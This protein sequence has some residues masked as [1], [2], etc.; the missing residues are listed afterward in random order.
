MSVQRR[1]VS[2]TKY[3]QM[4]VSRAQGVFRQQQ[5]VKRQRLVALSRATR[6]F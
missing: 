1:Q 4:Y 2:G 6:G 3:C 5:I